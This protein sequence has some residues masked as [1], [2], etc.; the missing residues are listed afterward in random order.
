MYFTTKPRLI[1]IYLILTCQVAVERHQETFVKNFNLYPQL[2]VEDQILSKV[3]ETISPTF[4]PLKS[5][6][7]LLHTH[8][9]LYF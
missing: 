3:W 1:I 2:H 5:I 7:L 6:T 9:R 4:H 8:E